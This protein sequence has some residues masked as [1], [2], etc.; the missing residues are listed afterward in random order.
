M[1]TLTSAPPQPP[2]ACIT[3]SITPLASSQYPQVA[4]DLRNVVG[5]TST[6]FTNDVGRSKR[7]RIFR[8]GEF[9]FI[10]TVDRMEDIMRK[11]LAAVGMRYGRTDAMQAEVFSVPVLAAL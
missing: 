10:V 1:D 4:Q 8:G 2:Q 5:V 9:S 6:I 3:L 11:A 7:G